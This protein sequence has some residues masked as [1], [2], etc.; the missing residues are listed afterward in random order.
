ML[1]ITFCITTGNIFLSIG[2]SLLVSA[3]TDKYLLI[4]GSLLVLVGLC[5]W[6]VASQLARR[7]DREIASALSKFIQ[8]LG[9]ES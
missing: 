9:P 3:R 2:C 5:L 1:V 4:P 8:R 7:R 6:A